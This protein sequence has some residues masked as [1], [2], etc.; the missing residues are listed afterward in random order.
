MDYSILEVS[1]R[2]FG[3]VPGGHGDKLGSKTMGLVTDTLTCHG[4]LQREIGVAKL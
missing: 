3:A 1:T 2:L 4:L